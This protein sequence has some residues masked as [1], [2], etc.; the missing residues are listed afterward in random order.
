[1][2]DKERPPKVKLFNLWENQT[3]DGKKFLSG[4]FGAT[5]ILIFQNSYKKED[6]HPDWIAY[7][8]KK[9]EKNGNTQEDARPEPSF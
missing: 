7:V 4:S 3:K 2:Q 9:G 1:M 5:S 8:T 6:K